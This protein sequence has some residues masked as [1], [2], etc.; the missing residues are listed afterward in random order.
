VP[1]ICPVLAD[2][3]FHG[4]PPVTLYWQQVFMSTSST[5]RLAAG[6]RNRR[7]YLAI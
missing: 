2:V 7:F 1:H 3:G 6:Q 4:C 5:P